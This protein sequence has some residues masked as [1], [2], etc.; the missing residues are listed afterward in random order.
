MKSKK[1]AILLIVII[2]NIFVLF[3][4]TGGAQNSALGAMIALIVVGIVILAIIGSTIAI[5]VRSRR[6]RNNFKK[7]K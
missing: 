5:L 4:L 6:M 1:I 2:I 7:Y 3:I